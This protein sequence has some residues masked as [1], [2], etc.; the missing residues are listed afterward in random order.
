MSRFNLVVFVLATCF[1][2]WCLSLAN[3]QPAKKASGVARAALTAELQKWVNDSQGKL[4][5]ADVIAKLGDPDFVENPIDPD[6][7]VNPVADIAMVWQDISRI[8]VVFKDGKAKHITGRFSPHI[9]SENITLA[10]FR[11]LKTGVDNFDVEQVLGME[12][13]RAEVTK[14]TTRHEW[15]AKRIL[16]INFKNG[17][18]TGTEWQ[19]RG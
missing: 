9:K 1:A 3:A 10:N 14:G 19:S 15:A 7:S 18:A 16:K 8:E 6:S 12:D 2:A 5:E 13:S 11:K 4:T 17:K